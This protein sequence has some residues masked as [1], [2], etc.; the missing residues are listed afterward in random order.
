[1]LRYDGMVCLLPICW[2]VFEASDLTCPHGVIWSLYLLCYWYCWCKL[3][4]DHNTN[5]TSTDEE[6]AMYTFIL[7]AQSHD[8]NWTATQISR[9]AVCAEKIQGLLN[10]GNQTLINLTVTKTADFKPSSSNARWTR[11]FMW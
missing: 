4:T 3:T 5:V 7:Q 2:V 1:M 10:S 8:R 9:H 6:H 11:V